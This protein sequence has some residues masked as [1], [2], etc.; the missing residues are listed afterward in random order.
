VLW[1]DGY[2]KRELVFVKDFINLALLVNEK[3]TND[4][5]NLGAGEE[6]T[7]RQFAETICAA[8]D[9]DPALIQ[10][11]T[12]RYVGAKSKCLDVGKLKSIVPAFVPTP[13]KEGLKQTIDWFSNSGL[14]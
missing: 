3:T 1:G 9:Y 13:L 12:S 8:V 11:D 5:V 10:Y 2:Q 6:F 7:I 14:V 4:I